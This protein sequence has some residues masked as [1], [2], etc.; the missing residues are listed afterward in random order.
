V[1][2]RDK[3]SLQSVPNVQVTPSSLQMPLLAAP[4]VFEHSIAGLPAAPFDANGRVPQSAQSV[5]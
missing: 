1:L 5:P 2:L 4:Q 3:Q